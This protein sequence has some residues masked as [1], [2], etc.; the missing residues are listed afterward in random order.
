MTN[1]L[2]NKI[3]RTVELTDGTIQETTQVYRQK[4]K[5]INARETLDIA[6]AIKT[7]A[8]KKGIKMEVK[9]IFVMNGDKRA[10][11]KDVQALEDYY[12]GKVKDVDKF[13]LFSSIS[14]TTQK[15]L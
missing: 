5:F 13:L 9:H 12:E 11:F 6:N 4:G 1:K 8:I 3:T 10:T 2:K 7:A 14:I 15:L